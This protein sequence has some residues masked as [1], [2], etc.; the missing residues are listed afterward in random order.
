MV[1]PKPLQNEFG[2]HHRLE[3]CVAYFW[4]LDLFEVAQFILFYFFLVVVE[5]PCNCSKSPLFKRYI[6]DK[7]CSYTLCLFDTFSPAQ[8]PPLVLLM[9]TLV[10]KGFM[11]VTSQAVNGAKLGGCLGLVSSVLISGYFSTKCKSAPK[12]QNPFPL[13]LVKNELGAVSESLGPPL[14]I[15]HPIMTIA[16][17]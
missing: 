16:G 6:W 2:I 15:S 12:R 14:S 11:E 3:S 7:N 17:L 9:F 10:L 8:W 13:I 1:G 5:S 4:S